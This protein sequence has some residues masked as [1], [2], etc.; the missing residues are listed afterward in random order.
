[1]YC[2][3]VAGN[4]SWRGAVLSEAPEP[5]VPLAGSVREEVNVYVAKVSR[6]LSPPV[7]RGLWSLLLFWTHGLLFLLTATGMLYYS[8]IAT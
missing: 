1:M 5:S 4:Y 8:R 7:H 2:V 6:L 3:L